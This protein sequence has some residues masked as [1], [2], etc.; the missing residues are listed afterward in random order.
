VVRQALDEARESLASAATNS[1]LREF[2]ERWAGPMVL[3][4]DGT[5]AQRTPA[6]EDARMSR[7]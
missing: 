5:I 4:E 7:L 6:A 2:V 3:K 1:E